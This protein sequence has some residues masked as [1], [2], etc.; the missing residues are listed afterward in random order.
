MK[1]ILAIGQHPDFA[2]QVRAA[3]DAAQYRVIARANVV[4]SE[5]LLVHRMADACVCDLDLTTVEPI[6]ALEKLHRFSPTCPVVLYAG[7]RQAAWEEEAYLK[8]AAHVLTKPVRARIL[9]SLLDRFWAAPAAAPAHP[10]SRTEVIRAASEPSPAAASSAAQTLAILRNF[11]CIL[12]H[13]L[14]S[15]AILRQFL[16]L[17]RE[18]LSINR[19][20]LFLRQPLVAIDETP[21]QPGGKFVPASSVGLSTGLLQHIRLS[22]DAGIGG[23]VLRSGKILRR[24]SEAARADLEVQK[25]FEIL[26][27]QVAVPMLDRETIIGIAVFDGRITGEPLLNGELQLVFHLLEQLGLAI[28]N[29]GLH[30]QLNANHELMAGIMRELSSA[31]V[32][33]S[34]K[35]TVLHANKM[36][37]K[38]F[39]RGEQSRSAEIDFS[40][41]PQLLGAKIYQV[42]NTGSALSSFRY[43][44]EGSPGTVYNVSIVPFQRPPAGLPSSV[45]LV[46]DDLTQAEHYKRLEIDAANNR[47]LKAMADRLTAELGNAATRL[48]T[49]QQLLSE[50][51]AKKSVDQE[52]LKL[53]EHDWGDDMKRITRFVN[54]LRYLNVDAVV[55]AESFPLEPVL[56]EA[57]QE[58]RRYQSAKNSNLTFEPS[59]QNLIV[60][61]DRAALKLA[62]TEIILNAIQANPAEPKLRVRT[63]A[64]SNGI[65][66]ALLIEVQDNGPGFTPEIMSKASLPFFTTRVVGL[67]LGLTISRKIIESHQGK[68]ELMPTGRESAGLVRILLPNKG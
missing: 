33:V 47:Q 11:S 24:D 5:P 44:P 51:L 40:D 4:E 13:S 29:I 38:F 6:W 20:A 16:L 8:G 65:G 64:Q 56:E 26:G 42:L 54:Q 63:Q 12:T 50:K 68:L 61:G 55:S 62:F 19:A 52:F 17:L 36:A 21:G 9:Q 30:D 18:I 67:G 34:N 48:S 22:F 10:F 53:M 66:P 1:T 35:L 45:L 37:R 60:Q 27:T 15:E 32:V 46:A 14:D 49:Y 43:E 58:A 2:E 39:L 59:L 25:E 7:E 28:K 31:C 41:L 23:H 3:L 57:F